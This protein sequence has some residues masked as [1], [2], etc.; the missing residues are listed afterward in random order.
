MTQCG[1]LQLPIMRTVA[2]LLSDQR[3]SL[4]MS[5]P[6]HIVH[7]S[8]QTSPEAMCGEGTC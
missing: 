3:A 5:T 4:Q 2:P 7:H 8:Q 6:G 1:K